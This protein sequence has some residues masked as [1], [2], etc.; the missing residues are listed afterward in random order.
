ML[1][2]EEILHDL[3]FEREA[4]PEEAL[5]DAIPQKEEIVPRLL[6]LLEYV[7]AHPEDLYDQEDY[8]AHIYAMYLLAYFREPRALPLVLRLVDASEDDAVARLGEEV[9]FSEVPRILATLFSGDWEPFKKLAKAKGERQFLR[10][11]AWDAAGI[12]YETR[13]VTQESAAEVFHFFLDSLPKKASVDRSELFLCIAD[14]GVPGLLPRIEK[15]YEERLVDT[16]IVA[17]EMIQKALSE[18]RG[19]EPSSYLIGDPAEELAF[20]FEDG[21]EEHICPH[22]QA[23]RESELAHRHGDDDE[24]EAWEHEGATATE[25][26][27]PA[28]N[29][30]CPCGSG[31]KF[32]RCC[33]EASKGQ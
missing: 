19:E 18:D 25:P 12:L 22:C 13:T 26:A 23:E 20:L 29:A 2:V 10:S 9:L 31:K 28:R 14:Y 7:A 15:A 3:E 4:L 1:T 21:S 17:L 6:F 5:R 32:K 27:P 16:S 11:L 24:D 30:P 8:I 33:G